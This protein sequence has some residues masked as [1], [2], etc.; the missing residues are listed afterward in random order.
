MG[1]SGRRCALAA[2]VSRLERSRVARGA[3]IGR[4]CSTL[5]AQVSRGQDHLTS[6][7]RFVQERQKRRHMPGLS[8]IG[9]PWEVRDVKCTRMV[10]LCLVAVLAAIAVAL[11]LSPSKAAANGCP[12][13]CAPEVP[14]VPD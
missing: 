11:S 13:A 3:V 5:L 10:G 8:R 9:G 7:A 6:R 4:Y 14:P 12:I 2:A 1:R